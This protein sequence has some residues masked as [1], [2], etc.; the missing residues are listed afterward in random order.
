MRQESQEERFEFLTGYY[1]DNS[2]NNSTFTAS[3]KTNLKLRNDEKNF[4]IIAAI[5]RSAVL[6][7]LYYPII[8]GQLF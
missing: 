3:T 6:L 8:R 5:Y 7:E 2:F 4:S 1:F